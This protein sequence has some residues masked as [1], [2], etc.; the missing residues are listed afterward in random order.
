MRERRLQVGRT[1]DRASDDATR[2]RSQVLIANR[3]CR[4]SIVGS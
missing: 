3:T 2:S 1:R 4:S